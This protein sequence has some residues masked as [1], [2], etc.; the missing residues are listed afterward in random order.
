MYQDNQCLLN[1]KTEAEKLNNKLQNKFAK[2]KTKPTLVAILVGKDKAS[3]LYV[4]LKEKKATDLGIKFKKIFLQSTISK[5]NLIKEIEKLNNNKKIN[6]IILQ[7]P[8]P[9]KFNQEQ[10]ISH[11]TPTKDVDG[12]V[13]NKIINPNI[14]SIL[15]LIKIS[16]KNFLNKKA[17]VFCNSK[18]FG[19]KLY[20]NLK[21]QKFKSI[22]VITK[23]KREDLNKLE[24]V[25][26][27]ISAV[28]K[29]HFIKPEFIKKNSVIID[30]G[31]IR[32]KGKTFGDVSPACLVK[33]KYISPVPGG[34]GPLT[35]HFLFKNLFKLLK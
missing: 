31:I 30:M 35:I 34:V 29:K 19:N 18:D 24:N 11:I 21:S 4:S 12:F 3:D 26:L 16:K 6:G 17:I 14:N 9:A 27:I 15:H 32:D 13:N 1:G 10:I 2:L 5:E 20:T 7:L 8:L 22:Q 33:T 25:D 23:P 28:G